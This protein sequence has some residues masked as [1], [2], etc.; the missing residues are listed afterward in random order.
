MITKLDTELVAGMVET[1]LTG[2]SLLS[3]GDFYNDNGTI[4][5]DIVAETESGET[6][7]RTI[8]LNPDNGQF[9]L[10]AV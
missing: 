5:L 1:L 4:D 8:R 6:I 10:R 3:W 9:R 7:N 2:V